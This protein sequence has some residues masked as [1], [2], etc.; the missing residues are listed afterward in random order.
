MTTTNRELTVISQ[1]GMTSC[2][3]PDLRTCYI[4]RI[5]TGHYAVLV[6]RSGVEGPVLFAEYPSKEAAR[7]AVIA[8]AECGGSLFQ[9]PGR[10]GAR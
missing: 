8:L 10:G 7:D 2:D 9:F 4:R 3:W 1:D 6:T 5:G